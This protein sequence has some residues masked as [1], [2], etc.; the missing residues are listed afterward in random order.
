VTIDQV[1]EKTLVAIYSNDVLNKE[2]HLKGGQ[3]L[4]LAY[5]MKSRFSGD[6]DFSTKNGFKNDDPFFDHLKE[7]LYNEFFR[8]GLYLFDFKVTRRPELRKEG[9]P[10]FWGGWAI[11]FKLIAEGKMALNAETRRRE[12]IVPEGAESSKIKIEISEYEYCG[13]IENIK[14]GSVQVK[15]YSRLLIVL[16]KIRAICQQHPDYPIKATTADRARDYYDIECLYKK[17][18]KEGGKAEFFKEAGKH[19]KKVFKAKEV[20]LA[21]LDKIFEADFIALQAK[22]WSAVKGTVTG[23]TDAFD[24]YVE[25]LKS[26]VAD[27]K[28]AAR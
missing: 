1:I 22:G 14:V 27:L 16:E 10:D 7:S 18:L 8:N 23:K 20:S 3:A 21:L 26:I 5:D 15:T 6:A 4:R 28:K 17:V 9:T 25:N 11:E 2:L 24:Y 19:L 13:S 12:A